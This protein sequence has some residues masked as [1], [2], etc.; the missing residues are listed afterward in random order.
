LLTGQIE[1]KLSFLWQLLPVDF[2]CYIPI[3]KPQKIKETA[4][5]YFFNF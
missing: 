2:Q 4:L 5:S 3:N 1:Q